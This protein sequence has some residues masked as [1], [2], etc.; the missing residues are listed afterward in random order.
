MGANSEVLFTN[1]RILD[2]SGEHLPYPGSVRVRGQRI[3]QVGRSVGGVSAGDALVVDAAG[4][5]LMP[6]MTEAHTHFSWND[7]ASLAG[8]QT[9]PLE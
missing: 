6:G 1:V 8:I 3:V 5:T 9:M 4:A 2:G 7:A